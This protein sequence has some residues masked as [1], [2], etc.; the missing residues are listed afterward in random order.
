[1]TLFPKRGVVRGFF[2]C[3]ALSVRPGANP[4]A[5]LRFEKIAHFNEGAAVFIDFH[6]KRTTES[7]NQHPVKE[8]RHYGRL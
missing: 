7:T 2:A 3:G 4:C 5:A 1:M 6:F 8:W